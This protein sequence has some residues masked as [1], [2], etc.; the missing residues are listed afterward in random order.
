M[1]KAEREP[2]LRQIC[3]AHS[4]LNKF[5]CV[6]IPVEIRKQYCKA[7]KLP[8]IHLKTGHCDIYR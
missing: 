1:E 8:R 7:N 5:H 4:W 3:K 2:F 6:E